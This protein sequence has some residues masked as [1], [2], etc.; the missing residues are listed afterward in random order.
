VP[1]LSQLFCARLEKANKEQKLIFGVV[2]NITA[3]DAA[4]LPHLN[5]IA[6]VDLSGG[7]VLYSGMNLV[8]KVYVA[9][10]PSALTT[11][12]YLSLNLGSQFASPFPRR[13][14]LLPTS[15][16]LSAH[17]PR[18]DEEV[19]MLSPV[20]A[21]H[22]G[23]NTALSVEEAGGFALSTPRQGQLAGLR[24]AVGNRVTLEYTDGSLF[25]I[26]LPSLCSSPLVS[27]CLSI[28]KQVLQR[29][30]AMHI[31]IKWYG[32]RNAPGTQDISPA[33]EWQLFIGVLLELLGY[34]V[35]KL[36]VMHQQEL[37]GCGTSG[38]LS[39][40]KR[41]SDSGSES[42]WDY[43]L[44]SGHHRALGHGLAC[45]L[46][47]Q[48]VEAVGPSS[49]PPP[50]PQ[51]NSSA[52][53]F[54]SIPL[55][56]FSLHL[57]YEDL[58]LNMLLAESL[59][60]LAQ[61][62]HQLACDLQLQEYV[63]HYW[64]DFPFHCPLVTCSLHESQITKLDLKKLSLS[65]LIPVDPPSIFQH[66]YQLICRQNTE[67]FPYISHV[68]KKT[69]DIVQL[70][71]LLTLGYQLPHLQL[72]SFVKPLVPPGSRAEPHEVLSAHDTGNSSR[73]S[74]PY[75]AVLLMAEMGMTRRELQT[76]PAG[77]ALLL[78]DAIY[79][80]RSDPPSDWPESAYRLIVRQDLAAQCCQSK[81]TA[82][83]VSG[84]STSSGNNLYSHLPQSCS[85]SSSGNDTSRKT[86]AAAA[87]RV[88][89]CEQDDGMETMDQEILKLRF[90]K[91]HRVAEVRRL[92]QSSQPVQISI[93]QRP[94]VSD[95]EFIEEQEKHLYAICTRTMALPVGRG[96]FTLRTAAPVVTET[97]PIPRLCL[98]GRAPP[99][100]TTVDLSHIE[101]VPNMNL[102]PLFHNGVAAGL[103]IAPNASNIDS[104]WIVFNKPKGTSE[105]PTEHAGS[106][107]H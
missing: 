63:L 7:I 92:L 71:A 27:E 59:P 89:E 66:V 14:S 61:L 35:D 78:N 106:S 91:D 57:L 98:T 3:K 79:S 93:T 85:P 62:L 15:R 69:K 4:P 40:K 10:I 17:D 51:I 55:I 105:V 20:H 45:L 49:S 13:S 43:L 25:R 8:G 22:D 68:N 74:M 54:S 88:A 19:C 75:R 67:P 100:G 95:H 1:T 56:V 31:L 24:D 18:F 33:Q 73:Y 39:K 80:C 38:V 60:L 34:D 50:V 52:I 101:V 47:L 83:T 72:D 9:G 36:P 11:S 87:A 32:V 104:N 42:D 107:W 12:S 99:R 82:G 48:P 53:L 21:S 94:E 84:S 90:S 70:I 44:L 81:Q 37:D 28:M 6:A 5:M 26:S 46:G 86:A 64:K 30:L 2:K 97:L 96:M 77:I 23:V 29:D 58:K 41:A 103:R 65:S 76:L 102:W 16:S